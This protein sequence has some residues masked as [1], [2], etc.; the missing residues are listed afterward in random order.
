MTKRLSLKFAK[1]TY[2]LSKFK[3][4]ATAAQLYELA[5]KIN[6]LQDETFDEVTMTTKSRI[7]Q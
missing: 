7:M 3:L 1:G 5:E 2:S 6:D 4:T